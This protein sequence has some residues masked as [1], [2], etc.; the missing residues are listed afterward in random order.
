[1]NMSRILIK[2]G[3]YR[4]NPV[5]NSQFTLVKGFQTGKKGNFVTV[6]NDGA[7]PVNIDE[8]RIKVSDFT[9]VEFLDGDAPVAQ[10]VK[11]AETDQEAMDRIASRFEI[12]DEM[13]AACIKGDIRAMI[14]SGPPGVGKSF[15]VEQ[16][17]EKASLFDK[18]AN[19]RQKYEVVKGAMTA[20]GLYAQLYRYSDKGNILVFDDCDSVFGDELSLNILKAA[21]DSGKRRRICWNSDSR[22]LRDEG[23]PNSFEFKGSAIFITNLKFENVRSKKLQDHLEALESRCHFIDLTIDTQRDKMLRV[24]Q[25]HRDTEGGLFKDYGFSEI[26]TE[27]IF[28]FLDENKNSLREFSIRMT[29]KIADLVKISPNNWRN[30]AKSTVCRRG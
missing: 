28:A 10:T 12:L 8:V 5:I 13:S 16:Q 9:D 21:L 23:I 6:K 22:L 27:E 20:L 14:V 11:V 2:N 25:V 18:I 1:M 3:E 7:F 26:Q 24:K 15:G 19:K 29:L 30:L 4:N 17:L